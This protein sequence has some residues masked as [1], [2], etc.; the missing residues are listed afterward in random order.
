MNRAIHTVLVA[1]ATGRTGQQIVRHLQEQGYHVRALVRDPVTAKELLGPAVEYVQGDVR[2]PAAVVAALRGAGAVISSLAARGK[3]GPNRPEMI[4]YEGVRNLV[5][6]GMAAGV[7]Q[8]V[9][10]S[11]RGVTQTDH[12]LNR[13]FGKVLEWK[14][15]GEDALRGSGLAYTIIR[16]A[17]LLNEPGGAGGL[18]FEQG[19]RKVSAALSIPRED[20][21]RV[22]V[23]ALKY[24][25]AAF[26]TFDIHRTDSAAPT[27]WQAEFAS[28]KPDAK[29]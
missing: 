23:E 17:S 20:V 12:A 7:R 13:L 26:R 4:D 3:E 18:A 10:V 2:E 22:C 28:L 1:G 25:E 15:K 5:N 29:P 8:F 11:S 14:L 27:D 24:P 6:A 19:D 16:P 9:L 21:A